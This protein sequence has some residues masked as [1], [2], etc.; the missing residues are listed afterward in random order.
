MIDTLNKMGFCSSYSEVQKFERSAAL[1]Q[2]TDLQI[3]TN[4]KQFVQYIAD[5]VDHDLRTLNGLGT[6]HGMGIMAAI[7]PKT[8]LPSN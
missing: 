7:T 3:E 2:G 5:N 8:E 6:F 1:N 4:S